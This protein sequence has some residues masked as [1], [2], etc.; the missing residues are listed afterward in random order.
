MKY[1][2][3]VAFVCCDITQQVLQL[4]LTCLGFYLSSACVRTGEL[5]NISD[6]VASLVATAS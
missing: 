3:R 5:V 6:I 2:V 1:V 4:F